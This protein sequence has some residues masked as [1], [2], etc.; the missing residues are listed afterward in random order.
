MNRNLIRYSIIIKTVGKFIKA[1]S[2]FLIVWMP[3][4]F[5]FSLWFINPPNKIIALSFAI[6][7]S[8]FYLQVRD[9]RI[10][11][12]LS[13]LISSVIY[14]GKTYSFQLIPAGIFPK[15]LYPDGF[16]LLYIISFRHIIA[17]TMFIVLIRD[18][19]SS[20][21]K[22][23]KIS[24]EDIILIV[25][26]LWILFSDLFASAN[27][28]I[29]LSYSTLYL[30]VLITYFY[31]KVYAARSQLVKLVFWIFIAMFVF[32]SGIAFQQF[33]NSSPISKTIEYPVL[34]SYF[35]TAPDEIQFRFRP[36]G[37]F[38]HANIL[39]SWLAFL[40]SIIFVFFYRKIN[41]LFFALF[42]LGLT[43]LVMTLSRGAWLGGFISIMF[44]FYIMEKVKRKRISKIKTKHFI[45]LLVLA[46][47]LIAL[48]VLPRATSSVN[49]FLEGEGG[50]PY[51]L[52]QIK[53]TIDIIR[54][55]PLLGVGTAMSIQKGIEINPHGVYAQAPLQVHNW[56]F[57]QAVE[58]GIPSIV[59]FLLFVVLSFRKLVVTILRNKMTSFNN[60]IR[61]GFVAGSLSIFVVGFFQPFLLMIPL[62]LS[63]SLFREK[64]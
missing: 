60:Y 48:F 5:Y 37:T 36:I 22:L 55:Y 26:Y 42:V 23:F 47:V 24:G 15:E 31:I 21:F 41:Y 20:G 35:G 1:K 14:T 32:Q 52:S 64:N 63:V 2:D 25:F 57:L 46:I 49:S 29:S 44:I 16:I 4:L 13:Y 50:G 18:F 27:P 54:R 30:E 28:D 17:F 40:L 43:V 9:L 34:S 53:E 11:L 19:I 61:L 59:L 3:T 10:S 12:L 62:F 39:G 7:F 38:P 58:H 6:L 45:S 56:Y 33:A 8:V 51:R